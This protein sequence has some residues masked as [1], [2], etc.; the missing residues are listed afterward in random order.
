MLEGFQSDFQSDSPRCRETPV[1]LTT[2]H[3]IAV[4]FP[5]CTPDTRKDEALNMKAWT[6]RNLFEIILNQPKIKLYLPFSD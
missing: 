5:V 3:L 2:V 6:Q 1:S 4:V